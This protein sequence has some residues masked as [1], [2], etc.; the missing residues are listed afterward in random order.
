MEEIVKYLKALLLLELS[1][2]QQEAQRAGTAT[3]K[4]DLVLAD[5]GFAHKEIA[6]MLDKSPVA[7]AK[8][9]SRARAARRSNT[10]PE[11]VEGDSDAG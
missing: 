10:P 7:V 5:S 11:Q 2:A 6:D 8:A 3:T 1:R 4:L 9:V